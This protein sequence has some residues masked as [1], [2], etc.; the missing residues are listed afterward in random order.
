MDP[1]ILQ[2]DRASSGNG[3][4]SRKLPFP[5]LILF[6]LGT[7]LVL[8]GI[9]LLIWPF[10]AVSWALVVLFGATLVAGGLAAVTRRPA[11]FASVLGGL[12]LLAAGVLSMVFAELTAG[13]LITFVGVMLIVMGAFWL[14]I[15]LSLA[16]KSIVAAVPGVL[17]VLAGIVGLVWPQVALVLAAVVGGVCALA[18]GSTMI[19]GALRLRRVRVSAL[20]THF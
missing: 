18:L 15:M 17:L 12:V 4:Q 7:I 2:P 16:A 8:I 1:I 14:V 11:T 20:S 19:W 3:A 5:W 13:A 6:A 9:G 10:V